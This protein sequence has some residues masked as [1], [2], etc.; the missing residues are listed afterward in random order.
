MYPTSVDLIQAVRSY[1]VKLDDDA[2]PRLIKMVEA[3]ADGDMT[4]CKRTV[5]HITDGV[6][7]HI[8]YAE[9]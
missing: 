3:K 5:W 4:R 7:F 9:N 1:A 6:L 2:C 8:K